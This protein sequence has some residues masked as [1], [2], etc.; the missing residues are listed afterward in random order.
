M[1]QSIDVWHNE[2]ESRFVVELEGREAYVS[3]RIDGGALDIEHTIV[4][5]VL[6][7]RGLA[8]ALVRAAYDYAR[9]Q[10]LKA[11]AT[12]S[13]AASW[14]QRHPEYTVE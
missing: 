9:T 10:G 2:K 14:L 11:T 13:Y 12:C 8:A 3:Y 4:P 7:G 6:S 1:L 5:K